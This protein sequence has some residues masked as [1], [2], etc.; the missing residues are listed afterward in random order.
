MVPEASAGTGCARMRKPSAPTDL[1]L[2][3]LAMRNVLDTLRALLLRLALLLVLKLALHVVCHV[4]RRTR[5]RHERRAG[6]SQRHK[7]DG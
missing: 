7:L 1:H 5:V 2:Q 3:Q 4:S 6:E